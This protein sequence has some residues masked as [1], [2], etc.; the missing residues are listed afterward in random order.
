MKAGGNLF[1]GIFFVAGFAF[2]TFFVLSPLADSMSMQLWQSADAKLN[3]VDV[4]SYQSRNDNGSYTTMYK[5]DVQYQYQVGGTSYL[6]S[7]ASIQQLSSSDSSDAYHQK[8]LISNEQSRNNKIKIWYDPDNPG[9]SVYDR[10]LAVRAMLV[11]TSICS[12]FMF[13]GGGFI[14]YSRVSAKKEQKP[15]LADPSKPWTTRKAWASD[16]IYSKTKNSLALAK[17]LAVLAWLFCGSFFIGVIGQNIVGS[18]IVVI[19]LIIPVLV[20]KRALRIKNE[21]EHFKQ[22][23][24]TLNPY[25]GVIGGKVSGSL[26]IPFHNL[27]GFKVTLECTK[28]WTSRSG[29]NNQS[30]SSVVWSEHKVAQCSADDS[31]TLVSFSFDVPAEQEPSSP[32]GK[33][34]HEWTLSVVGQA[35]G[36]PF[37]RSYELPVFVTEESMTV[38][39]ELEVQPLTQKEQQVIASRLSMASDEESISLDTPGSSSGVVFAGVGGLFAIIGG[40]IALTGPIFIGVF[41]VLFGGLF[42]VLGMWSWGRN[43]KVYATSSGCEIE[44][45]WFSKKLQHHSIRSSEIREIEAFSSSSSSS[46]GQMVHKY[47]LRLNTSDGLRINL[48]GEFNS[49]KNAIHMKQEIERVLILEV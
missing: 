9:D 28:H 33:S 48:G 4:S 42:F 46:N 20:T 3:Y 23:P 6:G 8:S 38:E 40:V 5:L 43:C 11:A 2:W 36:V 44:I 21:L 30:H 13:L 29:N 49:K 1:G 26:V 32:P 47:D 10:S 41:F 14:Y 24:V 31:G 35:D 16:V 12:V 37:D 22:V 15:E 18:I 45:F 19:L 17:F 34:Y 7:R 27:N 25:P 39:E